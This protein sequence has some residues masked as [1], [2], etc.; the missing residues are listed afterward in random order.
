MAPDGDVASARP[1]RR[2]ELAGGRD[3]LVDD[4]GAAT[5]DGPVLVWHHG[6]P[7]TGALF[8]PLLRIARERGLRMIALARPGYGG[9]P[10]TPGRT[11]AD[12]ARDAIEVADLLGI[13][14]TLQLGAS[15]GGPHALAVAALDPG[16][17]AGVVVEASVAPFED[18]PAWWDGMADDAAL[19][20]ARR[21]RA[22]R[23]AHADVEEF[24]PSV[25]VDTD[26]AA[27]E[28]EWAALGEDA[29]RAA[30]FGPDG[31]V[32]D[33]T[34]FANPW[35]ADLAA[36]TVPVILI[37]G[38]RDRMVPPAHAELLAR[39][40]PHAELRWHDTDGHIAALAELPGAIDE[41]LARG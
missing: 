31:L 6:S 41:L 15:G 10:A 21:G 38:R 37:H 27:L 1:L 12:S 35:G 34:A 7:H 23:R 14:R 22:A 4:S 36:I 32:D 33:D 28:G 2:V 20:A 39:A 8:E 9:L 26:W 30:A 16:R 11:V 40:V 5:T 25:F 19:R 3:V 24:D 17:V 13:D 18:T 29:G